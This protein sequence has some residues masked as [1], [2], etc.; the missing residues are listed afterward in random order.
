MSI[1]F[2]P[3]N[4]SVQSME[5]FGSML[6]AALRVDLNN[7]IEDLVQE[8]YFGLAVSCSQVIGTSLVLLPGKRLSTQDKVE[9]FAEGIDVASGFG[10]GDSPIFELWRD[11][12]TRS[13]CLGG[14]R[15]SFQDIVQVEA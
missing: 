10:I 14:E 3:R 2:N 4:H 12:V 15:E 5:Q 8:V 9:Q 11:V 6:V 13:D 1:P 7:L